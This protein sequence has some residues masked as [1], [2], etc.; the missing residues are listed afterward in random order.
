MN[1][2]FDY[3]QVTFTFGNAAIGRENASGHADGVRF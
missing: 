1:T 2:I 3:G